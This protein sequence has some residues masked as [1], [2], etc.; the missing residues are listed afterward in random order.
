MSWANEFLTNA[1]EEHCQNSSPPD[2]THVIMQRAGMAPEHESSPPPC[3]PPL[4]VC[5]SNVR[6]RLAGAAIVLIAAAVVVGVWQTSRADEGQGPQAWL[7]MQRGATWHYQVTGPDGEWTYTE[8]ASGSVRRDNREYHLL[9]THRASADHSD[10][11]TRLLACD[12]RGIWQDQA[13]EH[14]LNGY[15]QPYSCSLLPT[16][17]RTDATWH[18]RYGGQELD[19]QFEAKVIAANEPCTVPAGTYRAAHVRAT[20]TRG[21]TALV[22]DMWYARGV[23]LVRKTTTRNGK[24]TAD[25]KLTRHDKGRPRWQP[26][27]MLPEQLAKSEFHNL[28]MPDEVRVVPLGVESLHIDSH[29]L[30]VRYGTEW[31]LWRMT[32]QRLVAF[33]PSSMDAWNA[34][35]A[36]EKLFTPPKDQHTTVA[37]HLSG[38]FGRLDA[39]NQG[40]TV[41]RGPAL[42]QFTGFDGQATVKQD[43]VV[44]IAGKEKSEMITI[45]AEIKHGKVVSIGRR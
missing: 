13:W 38:I 6:T 42:I 39:A 18:W 2:L 28:G 14:A 45:H 23:G 34:L 33:D 26:Q 9:V 25:A 41:S 16:P 27:L 35:V 3:P 40:Q 43:S 8:S 37:T 24:P 22:E 31:Q 29:F 7:P 30:R 5:G 17:V 11:R 1:I 19:L 36:E 21:D 44:T 20:T 12:E 10:S 15:T 32:R 4:S